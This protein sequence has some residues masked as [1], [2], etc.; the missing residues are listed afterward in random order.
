[1][2]DPE[3]LLDCLQTAFASFVPYRDPQ[4]AT[5]DDAADMG[6]SPG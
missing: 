6:P 3:L 1:M 2:V 4:S 5:S